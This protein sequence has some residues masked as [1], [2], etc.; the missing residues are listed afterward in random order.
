[1]N[2]KK[3]EK[4]QNILN[5]T[6]EINNIINEYNNDLFETNHRIDFN[7][8]E[9]PVPYARARQ[10]KY[11]FYNPKA[12]VE[13]KYRNLFKNQLS[14]DD[15]KILKPLLENEDS[16]YYVE[17]IGNFYVPIPESD[18]IKTTI[19]KEQGLIKPAIRNGDIDNY[20][21]LILDAL[22]DVIYTDDKRVTSIVAN[23]LYSL[24]PRSEITINL[25]IR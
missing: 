19:L 6:N 25:Q 4:I 8:N 9:K 16:E 3:L 17:I 14:A 20:M 23:K 24:N 11:G 21:K 13:V 12:A 7:I 2:D 18:S 10:G 5:N 1:M 15:Y 22:H